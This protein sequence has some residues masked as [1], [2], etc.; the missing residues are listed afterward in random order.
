MSNDVNV[1]TSKV[2]FF[3]DQSQNMSSS[4][5]LTK[6]Q[7]SDWLTYLVY[8]LEACFL[9]EN[10]LNSCPDSDLRKTDFRVFIEKSTQINRQVY[11]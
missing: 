11:V 4:G 7:A 5:F 8:Q 3:L 1:T 10:H 2:S 6:E 9:A